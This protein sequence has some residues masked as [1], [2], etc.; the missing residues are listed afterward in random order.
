VV[1]S[2]LL[3]DAPLQAVGVPGDGLVAGGAHAVVAVVAMGELWTVEEVA[4]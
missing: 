2:E 4:K 1:R 3:G